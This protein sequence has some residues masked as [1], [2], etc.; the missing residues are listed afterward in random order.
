MCIG[1]AAAVAI[2]V[3]AVKRR[4]ALRSATIVVELA[5]IVDVAEQW[6]SALLERIE[7]AFFGLVGVGG[8]RCRRRHVR[9]MRW[10]MALRW[11]EAADGDTRRCGGRRRRRLHI[12]DDDCCR[13]VAVRCCRQ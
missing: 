6:R 10:Q 11:R 12:R 5:L 3:A 8:R 4:V 13:I 1:A 7:V 2:A 9:V